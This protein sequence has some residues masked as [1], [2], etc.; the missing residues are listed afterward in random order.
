MSRIRNITRNLRALFAQDFN[1]RWQGHDERLDSYEQRHA[2]RA[3]SYEASINER[4]DKFEAAISGRADNYEATIDARIETRFAAIEHHLD[5][6][7]DEKIVA[8]E[9]RLDD[10]QAAVNTQVNDRLTAMETRLGEWSAAT[11]ERLNKYEKAVDARFDERSAAIEQRME[12]RQNSY[13]GAL[14]KRTDER[15]LAIEERLDQ[16]FVKSAQLLDNRFDSR[17]AAADARTDERLAGMERH[18]DSR[19]FALEQRTDERME[20]HERLVD[21]K[22]HSNRQDIVDRTDLLLQVFEQRLDKQRRDL[23]SLR[24]TIQSSDARTAHH[25]AATPP[26]TMATTAPAVEAAEVGSLSAALSGEATANNG[27]GAA[28]ALDQQSPQTQLVSFRKLAATSGVTPRPKLQSNDA[29]LYD[30]ILEWKKVAHEGISNFTPDEQETVDYILS[31][32]SDP[33]EVEYTRQHLRRLVATLQ[34]IPPARKTKDRLLELGS[35]TH[36]APAIR[37]FCGYKEV[38]CA[39]FWEAEEKITHETLKQKNGKDSYTFELRNFNVE[40]DPFPYPDGHFRVVLCCELIEHLQCDPM[41][42]LWECN[43]VLEKDGFLLL[44]TPNIASAR[45]IEG[46]LVGCSPYLLAQYNRTTTVDQHNREYAPYEIGV[47][48]AAAGFTVVE[49]EAEDVWLRSNPAILELLR[50]V[51]I[52]TELRGDNIF[53]L[54]RKTG[55]PIERYPKELYIE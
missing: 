26:A 9:R 52:S 15:F 36:L 5:E 21:G 46:L 6:W 10:Y 14:D 44:T 2:E 17:A 43:R 22:L 12:E 27:A 30:R 39:D 41:H 54:A 4:T 53:A 47:A 35:L 40:R 13:E 19:F 32:I 3:D 28:A 45:A 11:E 34:R 49:L 1:E 7:L 55:A 23:H 29:A 48:L 8:L 51:D 31:F 38:S 50:K 37:K 18:I 33:K 20:A 42:M 24:E 16:Q 25:E